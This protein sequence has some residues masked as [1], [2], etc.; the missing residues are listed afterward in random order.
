MDEVIVQRLVEFAQG[1]PIAMAILVLMGVFRAIFKPIMMVAEKY[2][3]ATPSKSD[4]EKL[5]KFK[6]SSIYKA[7]G[8]ASDYLMSIK[9]PQDKETQ[10]GKEI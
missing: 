3:A 6:E 1:Y 4:N 5:Q 7:L 9:L 10:D 2:V 8:L